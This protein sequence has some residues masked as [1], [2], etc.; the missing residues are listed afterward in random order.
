MTD[1]DLYGASEPTSEPTS[2]D[3]VTTERPKRR[4]AAGLDGMVLAELQQLAGSLG[5]TGTG[6]MRKGQLV[7]AIRTA[8]GGSPPASSTPPAA[9]VAETRPAGGPEPLTSVATD[10]EPADRRPSDWSADDAASN[11]G[12][13]RSENRDTEQNIGQDR[14]GARGAQEPRESRPAA[15]RAEQQDR[16]RDRRDD[17]NVRGADRRPAG[18]GDRAGQN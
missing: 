10:A 15:A 7:D 13:D 4:R 16:Q 9:P 11:D 2:G 17:Q 18:Q 8:Q 6:R 5:I 14:D 1:T 3:A 12:D